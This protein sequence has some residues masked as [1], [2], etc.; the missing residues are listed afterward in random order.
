MS[1]FVNTF[2]PGFAILRAAGSGGGS[3]EGDGLADGEIEADGE[4]DALTD[5]LTEADGETEA[6][7]L[8]PPQLISSCAH[9]FASPE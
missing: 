3:G 7:G 9:L 2:T 8:G 5:G 4:I 1:E 6:E